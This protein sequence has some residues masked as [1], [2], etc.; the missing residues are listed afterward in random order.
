MHQAISIVI[1]N[2]NG[3]HLLQKNLSSVIA[4]AIAYGEN[5]TIIVVDDGSK[6]NSIQVLSEA[7]PQ[8]ILV[9]HAI[10]QGFAEA[11]M[12]GVKAAETELLFLLNS[13]VELHLDC[14]EKLA[15][16]FNHADTFSVCPLMLNEDGSVNRHSWNLRSFKGGYLKLVDWNV[17]AAKKLAQNK[18]LKSLYAC[19]GCMMVRKS[20][21]MELDG[22]HPIYKPFYGED[23]DLGIRAW[24][25]GWS[26]YF[27]PNATL[28]HQSQGSI[29]D[30]VKRAKVKEIRRRNRYY[31]QFIHMP[32]S[33]L[34]FCALPQ[35]L[36]QLTGE[37]LTAD[38]KNLKGFISALR[39][40]PAALKVRKQLK[41]TQ[42]WIL[43]DIV[44][45]ILA[46][47]N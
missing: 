43:T 24:Y 29:K 44:Q 5:T 16:Y 32:V 39:G 40:M 30:N 20:M 21:F 10:N 3:A 42:K 19:G 17:E 36:L 45:Q 11:V 25:R 22:F 2:Y 7:F 1:P 35:T 6:D 4:A 23:F 15:P 28:I 27:E 9:K 12:T 31:L 13:D 33:Q 41:Q 14:L 46:C 38:T 8:I 37:L 26:T 47:N 34:L 18:Q